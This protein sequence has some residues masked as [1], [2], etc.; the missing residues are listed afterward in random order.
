MHPVP[1][2]PYDPATAPTDIVQQLL[3]AHNKERTQRGYKPL[4]LNPKLQASAQAHADFMAKVGHMAHF[5]IG[6][7]TPWS[8]IQAAG[9]AYSSAAENVAWNQQTVVDVMSTWMGSPGHRWNILSG[10]TECGLAVRDLY[11]C[12]VFGTPQAAGVMMAAPDM[13]TATVT[14]SRSGM[15]SSISTP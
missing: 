15:A 10:N 13:D 12:A 2:S 4:T 6:D 7:G 14:R 1:P 11:W 8:R 3:E 5:G 9:Y